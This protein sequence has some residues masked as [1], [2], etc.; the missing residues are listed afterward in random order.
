[1]KWFLWAKLLENHRVCLNVTQSKGRDIWWSMWEAKV[2]RKVAISY[3]Y[4]IKFSSFKKF[5]THPLKCPY[6]KAWIERPRL[7]KLTEVLSGSFQG[8]PI[9]QWLGLLWFSG[10]QIAWPRQI[11]VFCR[12]HCQDSYRKQADSYS[13]TSK[14]IPCDLLLIQQDQPYLFQSGQCSA[15]SGIWKWDYARRGLKMAAWEERQRLPP[16]TV[17]NQKT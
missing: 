15:H 17:Y 13:L 11:A 6:I 9:L 14:S 12:P 3:F 8:S 4:S 10:Y 5:A 16:K 7:T 1:M 2:E